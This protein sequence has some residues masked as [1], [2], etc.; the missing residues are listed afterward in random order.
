[1]AKILECLLFCTF[2]IVVNCVV[3]YFV[4]ESSCSPACDSA[5]C[6]SDVVLK[7]KMRT[8]LLTITVQLLALSDSNQTKGYLLENQMLQMDIARELV[9]RRDL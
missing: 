4:P 8:W 6:V 1:M 5:R 2:E 7:P 9:R 3:S